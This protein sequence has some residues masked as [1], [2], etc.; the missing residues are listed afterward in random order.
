MTDDDEDEVF[1]SSLHYK[2]QLAYLPARFRTKRAHYKGAGC[3]HRVR[4]LNGETSPTHRA[5]GR[6]RAEQAVVSD[7]VVDVAVMCCDVVADECVQWE[8][9]NGDIPECQL[10]RMGS[11]ALRFLKKRRMS[12]RQYQSLPRIGGIETVTDII[13]GISNVEQENDRLDFITG[14][15]FTYTSQ[16]PWGRESETYI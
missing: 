11:K 6:S 16:E 1:D 10:R 12:G 13:S 15:M 9:G 4:L 8:N 5:G 14:S 7:K 2:P 3:G